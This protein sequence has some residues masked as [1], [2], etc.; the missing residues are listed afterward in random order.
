MDYDE[1]LKLP[2]WQEMRAKVFASRPAICAV[3]DGVDRLQVHH[4]TYRRLGHERL[5][6]LMLLCSDCHVMAHSL[7]GQHVWKSASRIKR[8]SKNLKIPHKPSPYISNPTPTVSV[9]R[10]T[11][12]GNEPW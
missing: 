8:Y 3:C 1:Y 6:D 2:H 9:V 10:G 5:R 4:K 11:L 12:T 7:G